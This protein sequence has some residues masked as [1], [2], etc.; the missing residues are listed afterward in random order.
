MLKVP[1]PTSYARCSYSSFN[2]DSV[3]KLEP[4]QR[5][6]S[7]EDHGMLFVRQSSSSQTKFSKRVGPS[8]ASSEFQE[9]QT[10]SSWAQRH[11]STSLATAPII[12]FELEPLCVSEFELGF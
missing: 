7:F 9:T 12:D 1:W 2:P 5:T 3:E 4:G 10:N 6:P 11:T 8:R